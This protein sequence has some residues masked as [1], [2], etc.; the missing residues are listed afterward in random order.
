MRLAQFLQVPLRCSH[1]LARFLFSLAN[2]CPDLSHEREL[3]RLLATV[4]ISFDGRLRRLVDPIFL[5]LCARNVRC[6]VALDVCF[7]EAVCGLWCV[8]GGAA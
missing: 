3:G 4:P 7:G 8:L 5:V 6:A 1:F 2:A